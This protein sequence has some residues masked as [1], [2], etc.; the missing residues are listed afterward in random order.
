MHTLVTRN[1]QD[2]NNDDTDDQKSRQ[3]H[4]EIAV[5]QLWNSK[6]WCLHYSKEYM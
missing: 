4:K 1:V 3:I 6:D 2:K 5:K